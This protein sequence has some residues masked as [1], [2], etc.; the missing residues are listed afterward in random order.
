MLLLVFVSIVTENRHSEDRHLKPLPVQRRPADGAV[1]SAIL[2]A[3][4][5]RS[6]QTGSPRPRNLSSGGVTVTGRCLPKPV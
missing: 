5:P 3:E 1:Q 2:T 4:G 6:D